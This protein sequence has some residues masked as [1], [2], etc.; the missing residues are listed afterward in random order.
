MKSDDPELLLFSCYLLSYIAMFPRLLTSL[1]AYAFSSVPG[2]HC[3]AYLCLFTYDVTKRLVVHQGAMEGNFNKHDIHV[4]PN[5][6]PAMRNAIMLL[7][8]Q[9]Y[10]ELSNTV[11]IT[12]AQL[13]ATKPI[14][15]L[16]KQQEETYRHNHLLELETAGDAAKKR[17]S[18]TL[19]SATSNSKT[20]KSKLATATTTTTSTSSVSA[21]VSENDT[22]DDDEESEENESD[23]DE[24]NREPADDEFDEDPEFAYLAEIFQEQLDE[25]IEITTK[26]GRIINKPPAYRRS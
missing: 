21:A 13:N 25:S 24:P 9:K 1:I 17:K 11:P 15:L 20:K 26:S 4:Q 3:N 2:T 16:R 12:N 5:C 18:A 14:I 19:T 22:D 23:D 10:E 7:H 6:G 8:D